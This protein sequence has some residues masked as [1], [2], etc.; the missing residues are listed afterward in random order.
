MDD[1][2]DYRV[3]GLLYCHKCNTPK[4][5]RIEHNGEIFTPYCACE[6]EKARIE[7]EEKARKAQ[8]HKFKV[9]RLRE[10]AFHDVCEG[11]S[12]WSTFEQDDMEN[13]RLSNISKNY[14]DNFEEMWR[15]GKGLMLY[16]PVGTGKTFSALCIANA[17]VDKGYSCYVTNFASITTKLSAMW[18]QKQEFLD[19]INNV[20]LL[21]IDDFAAERDTQYM[22]EVIYNIIDA[23]YQSGRPIIV[24]TN[25]TADELKHASDMRKQ[26]I[27][28]RLLEMCV[29]VFV[30]GEDR[31]KKKAKNDYDGLKDILGL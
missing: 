9:D 19:R 3:D 4:Q 6:C 21:V 11:S 17:I 30:D 8:D 13:P 7:E 31:R 25:L 14:A 10:F 24:T 12:K 23:R 20:A 28:S 15:R 5:F 27:Y 2:L 16:G 18:E 1:G 29:P 22:N 26:R